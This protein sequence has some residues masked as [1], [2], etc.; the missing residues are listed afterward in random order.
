[1]LGFNRPEIAERVRLGI[2]MVFLAGCLLMGGGSRVDI[3]SL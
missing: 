3:L 1:M 2:V